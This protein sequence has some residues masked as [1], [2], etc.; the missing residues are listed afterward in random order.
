MNSPAG[1]DNALKMREMFHKDGYRCRL[2]IGQSPIS[3]L[4]AT[5]YV[6]KGAFFRGYYFR[7]DGTY[8]RGSN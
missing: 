1:V 5:L 6:T 8:Y 7:E 4:V 2:D 3:K